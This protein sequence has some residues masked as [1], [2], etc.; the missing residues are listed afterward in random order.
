MEICLTL[1]VFQYKL[2]CTLH[3]KKIFRIYLNRFSIESRKRDIQFKCPIFVDRKLQF[4]DTKQ[5][6][7]DELEKWSH[8]NSEK[9]QESIKKNFFLYSNCFFLYLKRTCIYFIL[10]GIGMKSRK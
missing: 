5:F 10:V 8:N 4:P 3:N 9:V 1:Y 2:S 6:I 7:F